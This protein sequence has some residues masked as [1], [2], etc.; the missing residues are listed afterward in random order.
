MWKV[1]SNRQVREELLLRKQEIDAYEPSFVYNILGHM[2]FWTLMILVG[3][4]LGLIWA[5]AGNK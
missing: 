3:F 4:I 1:K 5:A 2:V